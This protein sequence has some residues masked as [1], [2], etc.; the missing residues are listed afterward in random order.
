MSIC[1]IEATAVFNSLWLTYLRFV[2]DFKFYVFNEVI[3]FKMD[4]HWHPI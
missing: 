4:L 3:N 1:V 2:S